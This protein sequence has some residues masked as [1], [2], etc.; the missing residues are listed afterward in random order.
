MLAGLASPC[1]FAL[2]IEVDSLFASGGGGGSDGGGPGEEPPLAG[3]ALL[4]KTTCVALGSASFAALTV[5]VMLSMLISNT[6]RRLGGRRDDDLGPLC[7]FVYNFSALMRL[8]TV[9]FISGSVL[10]LSQVVGTFSSASIR[11]ERGSA[12]SVA[13]GETERRASACD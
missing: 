1:S 3:A 12:H 4:A 2:L 5:A 9:F 7:H 6:M 11:W 10:N 13:T 8:P